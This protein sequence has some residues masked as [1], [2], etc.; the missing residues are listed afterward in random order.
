MGIKI[1]N[2]SKL[3]PWTTFP[4]RKNNMKYGNSTILKFRLIKKDTHIHSGCNFRYF[5]TSNRYE[6]KKIK[7]MY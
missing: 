3:T 7:S 5:M 2:N 1:G 4:Y 6:N